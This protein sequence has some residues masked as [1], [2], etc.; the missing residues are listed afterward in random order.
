M[1]GR[2]PSRSGAMTACS[3]HVSQRLSRSGF[4]DTAMRNPLSGKLPSRDQR[5]RFVHGQPLHREGYPQMVL[6]PIGNFTSHSAAENI[7]RRV[8][9]SHRRTVIGRW[10]CPCKF[11]FDVDGRNAVKHF[12]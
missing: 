5:P 11:T 2:T 4:T 8:W 7:I 3:W 9:L 1:S 12:L 10:Q 6:W